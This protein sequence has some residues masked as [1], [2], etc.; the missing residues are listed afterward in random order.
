VGTEDDLTHADLIVEDISRVVDLVTP[1]EEE[2]RGREWHSV[3]VRVVGYTQHGIKIS[4]NNTHFL[5]PLEQAPSPFLLA[6]RGKVSTLAQSEGREAAIKAMLAR[7]GWD[8]GWLKPVGNDIKIERSSLPIFFHTF[9]IT[10][11]VWSLPV[12]FPSLSC[13]VPFYVPFPLSSMS[14]ILHALYVPLGKISQPMPVWYF[15]IPFSVN[16]YMV[17]NVKRRRKA[18]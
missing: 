17:V 7:V 12:M 14:F 13:F 8:R 4:K 1:P 15:F 10:C 11:P 3:Q 16:K 9:Y 6:N 5:L 18:L 2:A